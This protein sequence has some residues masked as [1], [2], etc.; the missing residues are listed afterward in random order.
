MEWTFSENFASKANL[1]LFDILVNNNWERPIYFGAGISDDS[2]IGLEKYL[3]LEGYAH[4]LLPI[5]ANPKDTA[6]KKMK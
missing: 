3:Y 5:K 4:R 1:A 6:S 2:Y